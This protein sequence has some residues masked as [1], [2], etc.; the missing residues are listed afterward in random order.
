M[1][2]RVSLGCFGFA[3]IGIGE[4]IFFKSGHC[5]VRPMNLVKSF[6]QT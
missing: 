2:F 4:L 1:F 5:L 3:S 6:S